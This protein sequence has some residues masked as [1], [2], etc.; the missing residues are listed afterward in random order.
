MQN[1]EQIHKMVQEKYSQ[2]A[3][4]SYKQNAS[5][6]CGATSSCCASDEY[7]IMA[8]D[9]THIEGYV[10]EADLGLGCGI[11]VQYAGIKEGMTVVDLGSGAGNDAFVARKLVGENGKVIGVDFTEAMIEKARANADKFQY[12]NVEFRFGNIEKLPI[13]PKIADIVIS[14][15]V[16]NLVPDKKKAFSEIERILKDGGQF[17]ISDI[18]LKGNLTP[19][20]K[21]VADLYAGCISG[22]EQYDTYLDIVRESNFGDVK[23]VK[24]KKI[25]VPNEILVKYL[26][27]EE[28]DSFDK[29]I[30]I[31]SITITGQKLQ[32]D[33]CSGS[34]CC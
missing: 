27:K 28:I 32:S 8:E 23:V 34:G 31:Y 10:A 29:S 25:E 13:G 14:N 7:A 19:R 6:C 2:I 12:N 4:N 22:A 9:Y 11:P 16:I 24:E 3:L 5:S 20:L 30:Q 26:S 1:S 15:C 17:T 18:V 33:C 21:T